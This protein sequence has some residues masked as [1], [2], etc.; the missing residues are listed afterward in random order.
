MTIADC[1][2]Q[3]ESLAREYVRIRRWKKK[4]TH[5]Q[6]YLDRARQLYYE[7]EREHPRTKFDVLRFEGMFNAAV[8]HVERD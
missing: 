4:E 5:K 1:R 2:Y 3:I 7:Y 8:Y 6:Q